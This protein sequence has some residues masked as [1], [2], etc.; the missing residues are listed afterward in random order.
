MDDV[1]NALAMA[2]RACIGEF[3]ADFHTR[4]SIHEAI[5]TTVNQMTHSD[6]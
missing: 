6:G 5:S 4:P 1:R 3:A 2:L